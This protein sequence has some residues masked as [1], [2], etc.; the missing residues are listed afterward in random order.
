MKMASR[1]I[2][3]L[4]SISCSVIAMSQI[5]T[6][7][8]MPDTTVDITSQ[9]FQQNEKAANPV[10]IILVT[11]AGKTTNLGSYLKKSGEFADHALADLDD[12][13]KKELLIYNFTGGFHCCDEILIFKNTGINKYQ[14]VYRLFAGNTA[15]L[16]EKDF[17][18][19]FYEQFGY[20]F[21]CYACSYEDTTDEAPIPVHSILLQYSKGK[22]QLVPP[23]KEL[24]SVINDNLAKLGEQPYENLD[25]AISFDNGLRKEFAMNLAVFY[26]SFGRNLVETQKLFNKYY[27]FPDAKNVWSQFTRIL[28][29]IKK[30]SS[31]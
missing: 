2:A 21:T 13:G 22:L 15:I 30:E 4:L 8:I 28:L 29:A 31:F 23:D 25:D 10:K 11:R 20:F 24:R 16:P 6:V 27:K 19:N 9:F 12:D 1:A 7:T 3:I 14:Q 5:D 17:I 26:Y 18:Y